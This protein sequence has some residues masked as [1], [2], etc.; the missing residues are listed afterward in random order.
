MIFGKIYVGLFSPNNESLQSYSLIGFPRC[1]HISA[2]RI[3]LLHFLISAVSTLA[4]PAR[5]HH[6]VSYAIH[7]WCL[8]V[9]THVLTDLCGHQDISGANS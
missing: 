9:H 8:D 5:D 6:N 7:T 3:P 4:W 2:L 1:L